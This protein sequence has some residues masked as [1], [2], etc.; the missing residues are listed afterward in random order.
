MRGLALSQNFGSDPSVTI[1][2]AMRTAS[3]SKSSWCILPITLLLEATLSHSQIRNKTVASPIH[4]TMKLR[5]LNA[6]HASLCYAAALMGYNYVDEALSDATLARWLAE[7]PRRETIPCLTPLEGVDYA[8]Y[9]DQCIERFRN[10]A[11]SDTIARLARDGSDRQPKFI[12]P[13]VRT[14]LMQDLPIEG[15]ALALALW[16]RFCAAAPIPLDD[17]L[18]RSL[19]VAARQGVEAFLD[20]TAVF[21]TLGQDERLRTAMFKASRQI[22]HLGVRGAINAYVG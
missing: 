17:T 11:I 1:V 14:R 2:S 16:Q 10:P 18:A 9:L 20:I 6:S 15:F 13:T 8:S 3:R 21:D 22:D 7:L 12:L 19:E 5:L 4:E